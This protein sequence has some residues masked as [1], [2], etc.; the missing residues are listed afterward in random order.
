MHRWSNPIVDKEE[1]ALFLREITAGNLRRMLWLIAICLPIS[2]GVFI[3]NFLHLHVSGLIPWLFLDIIPGLIFLGLTLLAIRRTL[4][5]RFHRGLIL[6]YYVYCLTIMDGYYFSTLA[7]VGENGAHTIGLMI[8]AVLFRLPP[9][10]FLTILIVNHAL[11][12]AGILVMKRSVTGASQLLVIGLDSF[13]IAVLAAWFLFNKEWDDFQKGRV[14]AQRNRELAVANARLR[15]H[16]EEM[17]EIMAIA[18]HDLRSPLYN[19]KALLDLFLTR[20][21]WKRP[22]YAAALTEVGR[23]CGGMLTLVGRLLEAHAAEHGRGK[24]DGDRAQRIDADKV[25]ENAVVK[26]RSAAETKE[27]CIET[28]FPQQ[29]VTLE[30]DPEVLEQA[31]DN[32]LSNA[33][34]F[35]PRGTRV[36]VLLAKKEE[37]CHIEI[38]DEGCGIPENERAKLFG[39]FQRGT[40]RPEN[41]EPGTGLG[42]FIVRQLMENLGGSVHYEPRSPAGSIFRLQLPSVPQSS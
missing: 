23:A 38:H 31:L 5:I 24:N 17:N 16:N 12:T 28:Q 7:N 33:L 19:V 20:E 14:I 22:P 1:R 34:K 41:G 35:S 30:T 6:T 29:G 2:I 18:A 10:E 42:L 4:P 36:L 32:L 15:L 40:N 11:F 13:V 8:V 39:K 27:V 26:V 21:E 37:S 3:Y 25:I 9:R